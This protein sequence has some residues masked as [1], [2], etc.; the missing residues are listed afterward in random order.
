MKQCTLVIYQRIY[1]RLNKGDYPKD[2]A[3]KMGITTHVV[4]NAKRYFKKQRNSNGSGSKI[5]AG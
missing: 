3:L 4:Y 1:S 5:L 2:I